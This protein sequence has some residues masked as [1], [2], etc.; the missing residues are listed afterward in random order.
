[1]EELLRTT[2]FSGETE[3]KL[4]IAQPGV[5]TAKNWAEKLGE[6]ECGIHGL[7]SEIN[8]PEYF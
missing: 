7:K 8:Y 5:I 2:A 3:M 4:P 1:V 6:H